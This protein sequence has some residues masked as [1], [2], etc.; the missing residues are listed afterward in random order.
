[1]TGPLGVIL[2]GVIFI[3]LFVALMLLLY[4]VPIPLWIT[5]KFARVPVSITA[6][7][8]CGCERFHPR[9]SSIPWSWPT[10]RA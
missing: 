1:M 8:E 7:I 3:V 10:R 6:L 5:A 9:S 4:F 2:G